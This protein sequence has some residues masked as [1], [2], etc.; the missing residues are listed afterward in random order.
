LTSKRLKR[1]FQSMDQKVDA[2][3]LM[4]DIE[5][6][7]DTMFPYLTGTTSGLFESCMVVGW[8]DGKVD[9]ITVALEETSARSSVADVKVFKNK[10]DKSELVKETLGRART[11]GVNGHG[12]TLNSLNE[13][14]RTLPKVEVLDVYPALEQARAIKDSE[15]IDRLRQ[16]C[17]IASDVA[18]E[19]PSFV[20]PGMAEYEAAAEINYRMQRKGATSPNFDTNASFGANT[21]EPHHEADSNKCKKRDM[22]LFD[23]GARFRKYGS[24]ITR[25]FFVGNAWK[26]QREMYQVVLEAQLAAIEAIRP[27]VNGRD[28]DTVA[29][30][31]ID[32]SPYKGLFI[33][34]LGHSIGLSVHDGLRMGPG[35]DLVLQEGMVL[36]VEP[37]VYVRGKGGVRIEDDIVVTRKGCELLTTATRELIV[38]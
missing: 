33:H 18:E 34:S 6:N 2:V 36:T 17:R 27:G 25:S 19:I 4:N 30:T 20:K 21:A 38:I 16:A 11:I 3:V 10:S 31:I 15:E 29:R 32:D 8:P 9:L 37:G 35:V 22:A 5:P 23:F 1:I 12:L 14:K 26:W 7:L 24:D 28:V 13:I